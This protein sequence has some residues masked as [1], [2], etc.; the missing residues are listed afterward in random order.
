MLQ[1]AFAAAAALSVTKE[2]KAAVMLEQL[3][4]FQLTNSI[5]TQMAPQI[6]GLRSLP[7]WLLPLLKDA[8]L[9]SGLLQYNA[10]IRQSP[11]VRPR[12]LPGNFH[13]GDRV[14]VAAGGD[15]KPC[16]EWQRNA[17]I[18]PDVFLYWA[19]TGEE[20]KLSQGSR[21]TVL[22]KAV[23]ISDDGRP[24]CYVLVHFDDDGN[25]NNNNNNNK[26]KNVDDEESPAAAGAAEAAGGC[27]GDKVEA[28]CSGGG[29][30][31][32]VLAKDPAA[33]EGGFNPYIRLV[34]D[35]EDD[36]KDG[37][38]LSDGT[39]Q[40]QRRRRVAAPNRAV[41]TLSVG[42]LAVVLS[43]LCLAAFAVSV[44]QFTKSI[45]QSIS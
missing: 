33:P 7:S 15:G 35:E 28:S 41:S 8:L 21:G 27:C 6:D 16:V 42:L 37:E 24:W 14:E 32:A 29:S 39:Q 20:K 23:K 11:W 40:Q 26:E 22:S 43:L 13:A 30:V 31:L 25:I 45:N 1:L 4:L 36:G 34:A 17:P 10:L 5:L 19:R 12:L 2:D 44:Y 3:A 38:L 9:R 18:F